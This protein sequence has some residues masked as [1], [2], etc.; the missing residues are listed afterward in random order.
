MKNLCKHSFKHVMAYLLAL[1]L[2]LSLGTV[3]IDE[4]SAA[5]T[6]DGG[7]AESVY[8]RQRNGRVSLSCFHGGGA[9]QCGCGSC[10]Q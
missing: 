5:E 9:F 6:A 7:E 3:N 8:G 4:I 2:I 1:S 10:K